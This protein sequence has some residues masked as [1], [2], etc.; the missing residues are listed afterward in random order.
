MY[1][2]IV[3]DTLS[4]GPWQ[5]ADFYNRLAVGGSAGNSNFF[6]AAEIDLIH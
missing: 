2:G 5:A 3:G 1:G 6:A 4:I